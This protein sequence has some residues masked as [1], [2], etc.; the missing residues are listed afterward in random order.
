[1]N[2]SI[3]LTGASGFLGSAILKAFVFKQQ[4]ISIVVRKKLDLPLFIEQNHIQDID[5]HTDWSGIK[6][7]NT[8]I[9]CAANAHGKGLGTL[10]SFR[11]VN[12]AGTLNLAN[13]TFKKGMKRFIFISSIGVNGS[14]TL[15]PFT[16][17]DVSSPQSYYA[18]S[19]HEAEESLKTLSTL[20]GFELVIIR[21]PLVYGLEAPG[22]FNKLLKLIQKTPFLPFA[23][24]NNKRSFISIDNLVD[25]IFVCIEHPNAANEVFCVSDGLDVSIR[26]F[27]DGVAGG[28]KKRLIQLPVPLFIFKLIGTPYGA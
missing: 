3:L 13:E 21:P 28:L 19:K 1:M 22:S 7:C 15:V 10:A 6:T 27:A 17:N 20:L 16:E 8:V 11:D 24:C 23:L 9:H 2:N 18:V 12:T 5:S 26:E 4:K 25:F 14:N